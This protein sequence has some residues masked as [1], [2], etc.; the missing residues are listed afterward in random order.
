MSVTAENEGR[1]S[2]FESQN[3]EIITLLKAL[4][5][6]IELLTNQEPGTLREIVEK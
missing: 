4:V 3:D 6:G 5:L 2:N 1:Q